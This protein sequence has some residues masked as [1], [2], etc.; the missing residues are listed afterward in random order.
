[1][2]KKTLISLALAAALAPCVAP[3]FSAEARIVFV[4]F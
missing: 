2:F 4:G 1:M 3:L